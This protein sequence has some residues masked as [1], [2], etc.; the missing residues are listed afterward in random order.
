MQIQEGR[1]YRA[2]DGRKVGPMRKDAYGNKRRPFAV[3]H[4][5]RSFLD[6]ICGALWTEE[7]ESDSGEYLNLVSE[8]TDPAPAP[9]KV[10]LPDAMVFR[11]DHF[12]SITVEINTGFVSVQFNADDD[13]DRQTV[14]LTPERARALAA[15]LAAYAD[16]AEAG[17]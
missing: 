1:F 17:E 13:D 14:N 4:E 7:G 9:A 6:D 8:W 10:G 16:Q 5:T 3:D 11:D 12:G 15:A 2:R